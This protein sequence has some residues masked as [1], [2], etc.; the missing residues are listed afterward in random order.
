VTEHKNQHFLI[1]K[2]FADQK[3]WKKTFLKDIFLFNQEK[4]AILAR[5]NIRS[6][7]IN[8]TENLILR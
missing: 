1:E 5:I 8:N 3:G 2:N 4:C 7:N 6:I